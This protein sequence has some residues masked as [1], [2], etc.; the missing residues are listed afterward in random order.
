[1]VRDAENFDVDAVTYRG[2]ERRSALGS[3]YVERLTAERDRLAA[4]LVLLPSIHAETEARRVVGRLTEA[5]RQVTGAQFGIFASVSG[6]PTLHVLSHDPSVAFDDVPSPASAPLLAATFRGGP[7]LRVDDTTR[8]AL[9]EAAARPYGI[10]TDGRAVRSYLAAP[11][12][13]RS[14]TVLG[15]LFLGHHQP[16]AFDDRDEALIEAMTSHLAVALEKSELLAE[17]DRVATVLQE[18]LLPPLLP[19]IPHVD[20]AARYRPTGSGNLVGGDFFDFFPTGENE[21]GVV[22]GDVSGV[23]PEAAALTGIARYTIRA[24]AGDEGPSGVLRSLNDALNNQR[25]GDRFCTAVYLRLEPSATGIKVTLANGGHPPALLL[26]DDGRVEAVEIASGMLLGLF[27]D[28]GV[29]DQH[30]ELL[31][32]DALVLYTDGVIEARTPG[33]NDQFGQERVEALLSASAGRTAESIAR[34]LELAV[35]DHQRGETLDDVAILVVRSLPDGGQ[36]EGMGRE[37]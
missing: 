30:L 6:D 24:V 29:V 32:G 36:A 33:T 8:W 37:A 10:F 13:A 1:M 5:A 15:S 28:A 27:P 18:T 20:R 34:R 14:G 35:I 22:L 7:P 9:S 16:R 26:R 21:W 19:T 25:T 3:A 2:E 17:R 11:V 31:P 4:L 12:M 23:G